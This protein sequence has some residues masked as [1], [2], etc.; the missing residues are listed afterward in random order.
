MT[1]SPTPAADLSLGADD[2][3]TRARRFGLYTF[4]VVLT[5]AVAA[6]TWIVVDEAVQGAAPGLL[7]WLPVTLAGEVLLA[8]LLGVAAARAARVV[9]AGRSLG[10][11]A[12]GVGL[13]TSLWMA[14]NA[15]SY[16][17][18]Q[19][20]ITWWRLSGGEGGGVGDVFSLVEPRDFVPALGLCALTVAC[21]WPLARLARIP[22]GRWLHAPGAA[23][24]LGLIVHPVERLWLSAYDRG[25]GE[26]PVFL[27]VAS[28]FDGEEEAAAAAPATPEG[29]AALERAQLW[30]DEMKAPPPSVA[31]ATVRNVLLFY[32]EGIPRELTTL[33][34]PERDTT[35]LLAARAQRGVELTRYHATFHK[36]IAAIYSLVCSDYPPP[37]ASNI[38]K[39]NPRID[40]GELSEVM[41]AQGVKSAVFHGGPFGF[42]DKLALLGGRRYHTL[43]DAPAIAAED[44][45][46]WFTHH[47]GID[48]RAAVKATLSWID[49][50]SSDERFA[51][52]V[53]PI[54][55]HYPYSLPPDVPHATVDA[56]YER[57][58]SAVRYVDLVFEELMKGL[59]AR[60]LAD[61]TLVIFVADHGA[62]FGS[63]RHA[64]RGARLAYENNLLV[65]ALLLSPK[66]FPQGARFG[67]PSSHLDLLPTMLDA[68]GVPLDPRHRGQS[69]LDAA[70]EPRRIFIGAL[71]PPL[72][73]AG[74][75][76]G[77][78]KVIAQRG[79]RGLEIYDL[80]SDPFEQSNLVAALGDE[81]QR[82]RD[83]ALRFF[84]WQTERLRS[85]PTRG[86]EVDVPAALLASA[87]LEPPQPR[88]ALEPHDAAGERRRCLT[89]EVPAG[90]QLKVRLRDQARL[91]PFLSQAW[92]GWLDAAAARP[93]LGLVAVSD[94][95]RS[96]R[97]VLDE[98]KQFAR[99][100]YRV[101]REQLVLAL[102]NLGDAPASLC[103]ALD[104]R[105]WSGT[106]D[107]DQGGGD[108]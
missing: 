18:D 27:F 14:A 21:L 108:N 90:G 38:T 45:E 84:D 95:L 62:P 75:L 16:R 19:T 86:D 50:L 82:A 65:P 104:D 20:P 22:R 5:G 23:L 24:L 67:R 101:P 52:V 96:R 76:D 12:L 69:L 57:F 56:R 51:A 63:A 68:L 31:G 13:I 54:A 64:T 70:V 81:A 102:E 41:A 42:Y 34:D 33:G 37:D 92:V 105:S 44:P 98:S 61:E 71:N 89:I 77:D 29:W 99:V 39:L 1:G 58:L 43:L 78:R 25:L 73:L 32:A 79:G 7:R 11:L 60:G 94:G 72:T 40:C 74:F 10:P 91:F 55:A 49:S 83:D 88:W 53:I 106:F 8:G 107:T 9:V 47:W 103:L 93:E 28:V 59:E 30:T 15:L 100:N 80:S 66:L 35:P 97:A 2:A 85:A 48:D 26:Q 6:K 4:L 36:S 3:T 46:R 87:T 17:L